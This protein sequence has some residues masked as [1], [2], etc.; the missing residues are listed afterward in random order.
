MENRYSQSVLLLVT[1]RKTFKLSELFGKGNQNFQKGNKMIKHLS[2]IH[3]TVAYRPD[4]QICLYNNDEAEDYP[5]HWHTPFEIIMPTENSYRA[6]CSDRQYQIRQNDILIIAPGTVHQLFAPEHGVRIIFQPSLIQIGI[7]ELEL[8][9][10]KFTPA[11]LITPESFPRIHEQVQHL[12]LEI[13]DEYFSDDPYSESAIYARFLEILVL[14]G[15]CQAELTRHSFDA[16][17]SKQ[18][19]YMDKFL[20]I[21]NYI[22]EHFTENLTLEQMASLAGFSKYHFTRLFRQYADTSFYKY[23][24]QKRIDY[25]KSLL[26]D[27]DLSVIEVALASGFSSLSAFLRMF[28]LINHC[29]PTE[30]RNMYED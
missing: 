7:R 14:V 25:A 15:R 3:E 2:G 9:T 12:M 22:N 8:L 26:L 29:T 6:I 24:N 20:Y 11:I 30:Y 17:N 27:P 5:P 21:C 19:E 28:K 10:S 16:K 18:K 1:M 23:L 4:T 13:R